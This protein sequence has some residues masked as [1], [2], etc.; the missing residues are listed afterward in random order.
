MKEEKIMVHQ[1]R[2][3]SVKFIVNK[4]NFNKLISVLTFQEDN[5]VSQDWIDKV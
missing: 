5:I 3:P 2:N 1:Y 4:D